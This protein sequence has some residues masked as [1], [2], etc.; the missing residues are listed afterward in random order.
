MQATTP[1]ERAIKIAGN[2]AA[3]ARL[4]KKDPGH[5]AMW[6]KR[7]KVPPDAVISVEEATGGKV[8][9]Y[10][11]RPDIFGAAPKRRKAA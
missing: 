4:V 8:T 9:R 1:L 3:L 2:Q 11:L 6:K 7:G 10:D 5:I